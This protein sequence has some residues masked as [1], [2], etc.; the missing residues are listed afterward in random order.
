M[1][2]FI[3]DLPLTEIDMPK[4]YTI[5]MWKDQIKQII[6]DSVLNNRPQILLLAEAQFRKKFVLEDIDVLLNNGEIPDLFTL[7]E[8]HVCIE[9]LQQLA[10]KLNKLEL[11]SNDVTENQLY[12]FM[13]Q[14]VMQ[15]LLNFLKY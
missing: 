15:K 4:S 14:R 1:A 11:T 6:K 7:D 13:C 5:E 12:S 10:K 2:G 3:Q 8:I 9:S